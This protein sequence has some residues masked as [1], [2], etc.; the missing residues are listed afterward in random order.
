[1]TGLL[2]SDVSLAVAYDVALLDLDGVAYEGASPIEHA[3][4]GLAAARGAGLRLFFVTNNASRPP[5]DVAAQLVSLGIPATPE[6]VYSSAMAAVQLAAK[7]H[8]SGARVLAVGGPGLIQAVKEGGLQL[9]ESADDRPVAVLQ[10]FRESIC[11]ADLTEAAYAINGGAE[12]IATNLDTT[13][14]RERGM[15]VGNGSLVAAVVSATGVHPLSAGKPE[16]EIF[17]LAAERAGAHNPIAVGDRLNTD[18]A[19]AVASRVPS[20]HVLTGVSGARDVVRA[21]PT[22]RPSYLG[23]DLRDLD[24]PHPEVVHR[25]GWWVCRS[26]RARSLGPQLEL[27]RLGSLESHDSVHLTL[28]EYRALAVAAWKAGTEV[29]CPRLTVVEDL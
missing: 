15:A 25:D 3:A 1:M 2:S 5:Q 7:R 4:D 9:V 12:Y 17:R 16:P 24:A 29:H 28:D 14:P 18:I 22:Q 21:V 11:W 6:E 20:L 19:G 27:G 8:G 26:A 13:L 23:L 10:G